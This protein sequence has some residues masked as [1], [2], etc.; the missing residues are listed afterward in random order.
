[1]DSYED[2]VT[3]VFCVPSMFCVLLGLFSFLTCGCCCF[4]DQYENRRIHRIR[5]PRRRRIQA[6]DTV[7]QHT[8]P[9]TGIQLCNL[10]NQQ[11]CVQEQ[12]QVHGHQFGLTTKEALYSF[13]VEYTTAKTDPA[14]CRNEQGSNK[15]T[16]NSRLM[17]D[18]DSECTQK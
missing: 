6:F 10:Y 2:I 5:P 18:K 3:L 12:Y 17:E 7:L 9:N 8:R 15:M 13:D 14:D 1:M 16:T 11:L 4:C